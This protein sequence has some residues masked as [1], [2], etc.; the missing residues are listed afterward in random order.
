[1]ERGKPKSAGNEYRDK[2]YGI[3]R[4]KSWREIKEKVDGVMRK[5]IEKEKR[6][7]EKNDLMEN[8][9]K[10]KQELIDIIRKVKRGEI[11]TERRKKVRKEYKKLLE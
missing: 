9:K 11:S 7:Q 3:E 6:K 5:K 2:L 10:T 4:I 8:A 1:M